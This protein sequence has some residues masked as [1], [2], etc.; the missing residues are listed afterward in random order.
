MVMIT[1]KPIKIKEMDNINIIHRSPTFE[2][3]TF[4]QDSVDWGKPDKEAIKES[5][6]M[7]YSL[8]AL[9]KVLWTWC[10]QLI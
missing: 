10:S 4:L 1:N 6:K 3:Y 2:E 8:F 9:K 7:P 5:I